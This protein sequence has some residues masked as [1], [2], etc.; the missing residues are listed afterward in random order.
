VKHPICLINILVTFAAF[1][2]SED[3][4]P[5]VER[6]SASQV[7]EAP[8]GLDLTASDALADGVY[9]A[10]DRAG[11]TDSVLSL[12]LSADN[13][14][15]IVL[16]W[17]GRLVVNGDGPDFAV[18]ENAFQIGDSGD[19]FMDPVVVEVSLDGDVWVPFPFD[20]TAPDE[21][22]YSPNPDHWRGFAGI[23]PVRL[24]E[25]DNPVDPMDAA[26]AGGDH[27]DLDDLSDAPEAQHIRQEGFYYLRL[28][29]AATVINPDTGAPF[30][31]D[32][33]ANGPDIDGVYAAQVE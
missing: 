18:F 7:V 16:G 30:V 31:R 5:S 27:F 8:A 12:G 10:G 21:T 24:N 4:G 2:C 9:G 28:T 13:N 20:Y 1:A 23:S 33:A 11:N 14:N 6:F 22:I 15:Y 26:L 17:N 25:A 3:T 29:A 32:S 19:R